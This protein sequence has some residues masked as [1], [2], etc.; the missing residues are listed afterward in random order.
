RNWIGKSE[1]IRFKQKIKDLNIEFEVYDSVPQTFMAQTFA[2]IAPDHPLIPKLVENTEHEKP[3]T[4]FVEKIR[5]KKLANEFEYRNDI[6]GI[7]TGRYIED[8][9][10]TGDL[11]LW[12]ASFVIT[13]YGTGIVNSSAHDERDFAFAKKYNIPLRPVMFPSDKK[14]AEKIKNLEVCYHHAPEGIMQ[15]PEKFKG[16]TWED[17]RE[18][19]IDYL[20][21]EGM[22]Y[23]STEYRLRDWILSRQRYWGTPIPMVY[24]VECGYEP[25][26]ESDLPVRL[27]RLDDYKP[28]DD[29]SSPLARAKSWVKTKCPKCSGPAKRETDTMDTFVDSSWYFLR[30]TDPNNKKELASKDKMKQWLPVDLYTGGAEHNTMHL[31][32]SRFFTKALHDLGIVD[33]DEP[34][35]VRRNH[36]IV[37]GPDGNKMSKSKG[38]V[39]DPDKEVSEYGADTVRMYL[40]FLGPYDNF[41]GPWNPK[42]INGI[43]RFVNR[44]WKLAHNA[45]PTQSDNELERTLHKTIKKV[46]EDIENLH[47]NTAISALMTLLNEMEKTPPTEKQFTTFIQLLSPFAPH[48]TEEIWHEHLNNKK[49]IHLEEWPK[50]DKKLI[51]DETIKIAV[52]FNGKTRGLIELPADSDKG[53]ITGTAQEDPK[54]SKY[55]TGKPKRTIFVKNKLINFVIEK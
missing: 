12:V 27:P 21:K 33:F 19:I 37:L 8:P 23:R 48:L 50:F 25:V 34:F 9:F 42:S 45:Y 26:D 20:E 49:S 39:I 28:T 32:Y 36:G 24:C 54:L 29:G 43:F 35:K 18:D 53:T 7:F 5:K 17:A 40:A 41:V 10:G 11:P 16:R 22:G 46:S 30:Y 6:D 13:D 2:V 47:F 31:L 4:E 14:L 44:V 51:T 52:Q 3:V 15:A 1:G 55:F 38:N